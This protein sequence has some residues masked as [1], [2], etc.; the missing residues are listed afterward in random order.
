MVLTT[1]LLYD[2]KSVR[3]TKSPLIKFAFSASGKQ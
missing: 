3:I 1:L 2:H